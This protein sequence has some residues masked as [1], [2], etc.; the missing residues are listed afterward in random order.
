[1]CTPAVIPMVLGHHCDARSGEDSGVRR[2]GK[3]ATHHL[4]RVSW[5]YCGLVGCDTWYDKIRRL[6]A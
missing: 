1:M 3:I 6:M 5:Q 4:E 2:G